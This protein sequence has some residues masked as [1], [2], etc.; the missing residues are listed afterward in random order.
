MYA[1]ILI[2]EH[3]YDKR[4]KPVQG[5]PWKSSGDVRGE[6]CAMVIRPSKKTDVHAMSRIY[7]QTWRDTYLSVLPYD[8]LFE[9]SAPR[10]EQKFF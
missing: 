3:I 4:Y 2:S 6:T 5:N 10:H 7:V 8:Y 9:M 1:A